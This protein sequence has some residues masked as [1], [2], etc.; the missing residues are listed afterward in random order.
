MARV[1]AIVN[2]KGGVGKTTTTVNL[3]AALAEKGQRVLLVDLD[4][5]GSLTSGLGVEETSNA[6]TTYQILINPAQDPARSI[7]SVRERLDLIPADIHLAAAEVELVD[8][9]SREYLLR[10]ALSPLRPQYDFVLIDCGPNLGLLTVNALTA[11]D[12]VIIPLL[13]EYLS[14]RGMGI[15]FESIARVR[16]NL[17]GRLRILGI[18]PVMFDSRPTHMRDV[19][20]EV[21]DFFGDY[22]FPV[23]VPKS[24]RFAEASVAGMP[25]LEYAPRHP[26]A[27]AYRQLAEVIVNGQEEKES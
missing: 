21:R 22:T 19:L 26:G 18:L 15:L 2:Q 13:C 10:E 8:Q 9:P 11:A 23:V 24:I 16:R 6:V 3:G 14:L 4:P 7:I 20:A 5:Q 1:I 12:E 25:I 17:N 27:K